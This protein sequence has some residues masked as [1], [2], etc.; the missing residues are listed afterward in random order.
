MQVTS[1]TLFHFTSSLKNLKNIL[2][3]KFRLTYCH[4]EYFLTNK[5]QSSYYPMLSFCDIPLSLAKNQIKKYGPYAIGMSKDWAM[6]NNLNPVVY[7]EKDS[8]LAKDIQSTLTNMLEWTKLTNENISAIFQDVKK[9][10][11][12][13]IVKSKELLES[14]NPELKPVA[15][16][17]LEDLVK[18]L[19]REYS[20]LTDYKLIMKSFSEITNYSSNLFRY[21]KNYKGVLKRKERI[22][23][24]YR[25]YDEREWRYIPELNDI[26]VEQSLNIDQY[27]IYREKTKRKPF[28][29][30]INLSFISDDIKYLLVKSNKEIPILIKKIKT[31]DLAKDSTAIDILTTKIITLDQ[32]NRDF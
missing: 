6:K 19:E 2:D 15:V 1:D 26:R 12:S 31:S 3:I 25:F 24:N 11:I 14:K 18:K 9:M 29:E 8:L 22:I 20:L 10:T 21:I 32:I 5:K 27:K 23:P 13:Q 7:I 4:E 30:G 16:S 17:H 28:I